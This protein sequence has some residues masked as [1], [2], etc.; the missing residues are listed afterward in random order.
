M[1]RFLSILRAIPGG[2]ILLALFVLVAASPKGFA[3]TMKA[4]DL[5]EAAK[6]EGRLRIVVFPSLK[7]LA[8]VFEK[9]YGRSSSPGKVSY[10][11]TRR[12]LQAPS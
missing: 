2:L 6:K 7:P 9:E 5:A 1:K 8:E 4:A 10:R 12:F 3:Q 11:P